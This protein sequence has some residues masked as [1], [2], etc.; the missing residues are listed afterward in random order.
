MTID[1]GSYLTHEREIFVVFTNYENVNGHYLL[2]AP[3]KG[4]RAIAEQGSA[5]SQ[6]SASVLCTEAHTIL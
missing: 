1:I 6:G 4:R 2:S 5:R 3:F